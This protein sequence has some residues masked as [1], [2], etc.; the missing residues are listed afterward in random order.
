[1][2]VEHGIG[3]DHALLWF[4]FSHFVLKKNNSAWG[5]HRSST[6]APGC[7]LNLL[8]NSPA[9]RFILSWCVSRLHHDVSVHLSFLNKFLS[10]QTPA[11]TSRLAPKSLL[12]QAL[13][14]Y[15]FTN[16]KTYRSAHYYFFA[17]L[18]RFAPYFER[19]CVRFATPA[20]SS[21]P[22]TM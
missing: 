2:V 11:I 16:L 22:R 15:E 1:M 14:A 6:S 17:A 3:K 19:R 18:G 20:V 10:L 5:C 13:L 7:L 4:C 8:N 12:P 21:V 9:K